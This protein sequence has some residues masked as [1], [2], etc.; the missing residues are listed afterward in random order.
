MA[1]CCRQLGALTLKNF[2][3]KRRLWFQTLVEILLPVIVMAVIVGIHTLSTVTTYQ[4][5]LLLEHATP[6]STEFGLRQT[7]LALVNTTSIIAF[8]PDTPDTRQLRDVI[9]DNILPDVRATRTSEFTRIFATNDELNNYILD[10]EYGFVE[11]KP[12]VHASID[13]INFVGPAFEYAIR[14]NATNPASLST[15]GG[16]P[17][18]Y[19]SP[20]DNVAKGTNY[21]IPFLFINRG[22]LYFQ[23][24][25]DAFLL[26]RSGAVPLR[27]FTHQTIDEQYKLTL[28][29]FPYRAYSED[30]FA[31]FI[32]EFIGIFF[33]LIFI[34]PVTRVVAAVVQEK[35]LRIKEGMKMMGLL[36]SALVISYSIVYFV[37]FAI[38]SILIAAVTSGSIYKHSNFGFI[39]FFFFCF[40]LSVFSFAYFVSAFFDKSRIGATFSA[41]IFLA[42]FFVYYGTSGADVSEGAKILS[43]L[44]PPACLAHGA[45]IAAIL[46]SGFIGVNQESANDLVNNFRFISSIGML[47]FDFIFFLILGVYFNNVLPSEFG[48]RKPFYYPL[49]FCCSKSVQRCCDNGCCNS[50]ARRGVHI[51]DGDDH[52]GRH[53]SILVEREDN[54]NMEALVSVYNLRKTFPSEKSE[55]FVAVK[56]LSFDMYRGSIFSLLGHNGAGKSTT[57]NVLTGLYNATSGHA[58]ILGLDTRYDM[59]KIRQKIGVCPQ[60]DVLYPYLTVREH[61]ELYGVIKGVSSANLEREV[62]TTIDDV[63]LGPKGDNKINALAGSLSGGQ[64]RKLSVGIA[65]IG[66]SEVV[67]LDEPSSGMDV[68]SQ[69]AIW[70]ILLKVKK[71]R[72]IVLTTH[73]M[74]EAELGDRIAIMAGGKLQC[75]GSSLF[76]KNLHGVGYTLSI[77]KDV[78]MNQQQ[79]NQQQ[80]QNQAQGQAQGQGQVQLHEQQHPLVK[81]VTSNFPFAEV[82]SDAGGEVSFRLPFSA[83]AQFPS[84]FSQLD[85]HKGELQITTFSVSV[86]TLTEVFL[87]VG[88]GSNDAN[89]PTVPVVLDDISEQHDSENDNAAALGNGATNDSDDGDL[90]ELYENT[91]L[92]DIP[93]PTSLIGK[94]TIALIIKRWHNLKRDRKAWMWQVVYPG[95]ILLASSIALNFAPDSIYPIRKLNTSLYESPNSVPINVNTNDNVDGTGIINPKNTDFIITGASQNIA[96][97]A[98]DN[99]L[100]PAP[101]PTD[102]IKT[103]VTPFQKHLIETSA[104]NRYAPDS[105]TTPIHDVT[106]TSRYG[107]FYVGENV[108][109]PIVQDYQ[110]ADAYPIVESYL[111]FNTT[112]Q[113]SIPAFKNAYTN[114]LLRTGLSS[115]KQHTDPSIDV[116]SYSITTLN[117]PLPRT[118]TLQALISSSTATNIALAMC[119]VPASYVAFIV[120]ERSDKTKHLQLISGVSIFAYWFSSLIFDLLNFILPYAIMMIIIVAFDVTAL[121]NE[122]AAATTLILWLFALSV[123]PFVYAI[124]FLFL[125]HATAQNTVLLLNF[126]LSICLY[127]LAFVLQVIESTREASKY[128][129]YVFRLFPPYALTEGISNIMLRDSFSFG[130]EGELWS[131]KIIGWPAAFL[132]IDFFLY[133]IIIFIIENASAHSSSITS[134]ICC[135]AKRS[136]ST[137]GEN[138][139]GNNNQSIPTSLGSYTLNSKNFVDFSPLYDEEEIQ[140]DDVDAEKERIL[141][142]QINQDSSSIIIGGLRKVYPPRMQHPSHVAVRNLF[143]SVRP[144]ECFGFLGANGA[145]KTTTIRMLTGDELPTLGT[146]LLGGKDIVDSPME[147]RKLVGYCPQFDA[148]SPLLSAR[149]NLTL[150][151]TLK[152]A[153]M[154]PENRKLLVQRLL[155]KVDLKKYADKPSGTY[156]GGNKRKLSVGIAL[157]GNPPVIFLDEPSTGMDPQARRSMWDVIS[158]TMKSRALVLTTHSMEECEALCDKIGIMTGGALRCIGSSQHLKS[159]FGTGYQLVMKANS[160]FNATTTCLDFMKSTFPHAQTVEIH[161]T[162]LKFKIPKENLTMSTMFQTLE[163]A[164]NSG[165]VEIDSY[166]VSDTDLDQIFIQMVKMQEQGRFKVKNRKNEQNQVIMDVNQNVHQ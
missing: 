151:A 90:D 159:K 23:H 4:Q 101:S 59:E 80:A 160:K 42:L 87:K 102:A 60:H 17:S 113:E 66:G 150:Y 76:L 28:Q 25:I 61:L 145:G 44:A 58:T 103:I 104:P 165:V 31:S 7:T 26:N 1:G 100:F 55:P 78:S 64:K 36:D 128:L 21:N 156:S 41:I 71:D 121:L 149:E 52:D 43:C 38:T 140:D 134:K 148:F 98:V 152:C 114:A 91:D 27:D 84:L 120:K 34:Y 139:Q 50:R 119:F 68:A 39:F 157:I 162:N 10:P 89:D 163:D 30:D 135:A 79:Q 6:F 62:L 11:S 142:G 85:Q 65:L 37:M 63:G 161:G 143:F 108:N 77:S 9:E 123:A 45:S 15:Y 105:D 72:V 47:I 93:S 147:V 115:V 92:H 16:V 18:T 81:Y 3:L 130:G 57:I 141:S 125:D 116:E 83:S 129:K 133:S 164:K 137:D 20:I 110:T 88:H 94:H 67:F 51:A 136:S 154:S 95:I 117:S 99:A 144:G 12:I 56:G 19:L 132:A 146:A 5:D 86:T 106:E 75:I 111:F 24:L 107:A 35:E 14:M 131:M 138:R 118:I 112:A 29:P 73:Y 70:D 13:A 33:T 8:S 54:P 2:R 109:F 74:E 155:K 96:P 153:T 124:S 69:R 126:L 46:E 48:Q 32:G 166:S 127:V 82:L 22:Y 97:I 53:D 40:C 122:G 158:R 49:V